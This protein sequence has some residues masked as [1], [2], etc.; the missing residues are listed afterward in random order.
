MFILSIYKIRAHC[1]I[2]QTA[3]LSL[4]ITE[5]IRP[6][7]KT[8]KTLNYKVLLVFAPLLLLT[9]ILG[10]VIPAPSFNSGE[11]PY[12]IFNIFFSIIGFV[13]LLTKKESYI[14]GFNIGFGLID[15][16]Q[17]V[18]SFLHIFPESIF[19]WTRADDIL[20]IVLGAILAF[21]GFYGY[22]SE[23]RQVIGNK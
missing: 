14:R 16:Y 5:I 20:H 18:A 3:L 6:L 2:A 19:K 13:I 4:Q 12:N 10:F 9:G 11:L 8:P 21:V 17:A 15:L 23:R 22:Y 1:E 7:M